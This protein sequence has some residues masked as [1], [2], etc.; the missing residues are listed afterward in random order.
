[1]ANP[2]QPSDFAEVVRL[3]TEKLNDDER[4]L[5]ENLCRALMRQSLDIATKME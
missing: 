3:V 1:M 2:Q 5:I 4:K